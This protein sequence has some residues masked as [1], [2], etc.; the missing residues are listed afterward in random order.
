MSD[1]DDIDALVNES[2]SWAKKRQPFTSIKNIFPAKKQKFTQGTNISFNR[3]HPVIKEIVELSNAGDSAGAMAKAENKF[4][5]AVALHLQ[6]YASDDTDNFFI[7]AIVGG[8]RGAKSPVQILVGFDNAGNEIIETVSKDEIYAIEGRK[9]R[10]RIEG[11]LPSPSTPMEV[12]SQQPAS[13]ES[14]QEVI[15]EEEQVDDDSLAPEDD[16]DNKVEENPYSPVDDLDSDSGKNHD[17]EPVATGVDGGNPVG[18]GQEPSSPISDMLRRLLGN[19]IV[20]DFEKLGLRNKITIE[21]GVDADGIAVFNGRNG[22]PIRAE[23]T[24]GGN[25]IDTVQFKGLIQDTAFAGVNAPEDAKPY[26]ADDMG[27]K[28]RAIF[29]PKILF[30]ESMKGRSN[31]LERLRIVRKHMRSLSKV[32]GFDDP[33]QLEAFFASWLMKDATTRL[34]GIPGTGKTTVISSAATLMCN[35]YGFNTLKRYM[36]KGKVGMGDEHEPY[37]YPN[38]QEYNVNYGSKEYEDVRREWESWRFND[39][40]ADSHHSGAYVYDFR[41]L[42]KGESKLPMKPEAFRQLLFGCKVTE[43]LST[44]DNLLRA[45]FVQSTP[46]TKAE[47]SGIFGGSIPTTVS[48][49]TNG[50]ATWDGHKLYNDS[51][52]NQGYGLREFMLEHFY[53]SRLDDGS[54]G[55]DLI[56]NEMLMEIGIAKVDYDKRAEEILYGIEIRQV[57]TTDSVTGNTVASYEFEPTPRPIVTQPIKFFN[58]ANRSGS[59]VEDAILGLIAEKT[60]EY[61]G[62]TFTS[63]SFISFMDTNPHQKGNDL[64]FVDRIDMEL[65]LGSLSLG[66]RFAALSERYGSKA[67]GSVPQIQ[68]IKRMENAS[69]SSDYLL[70]MRFKDLTSLWTTV[71]KVPFNPSGISDEKGGALLDISMLSVL[72]TQRFMVKEKGEKVFGMEHIYS[73]DDEVYASPLVDI[74]TTTNLSYESQHKDEIAK[75]GT[76]DDG[77]KSQAPVLIKRMLGFRFTNSLIKMT[78]ALAFLRGKEYVTRQE[79]IDSLPYC[80]GHRLGPAREGEDPK[81]RDSGIVSDGMKFTNEQEFIRQLIVHGYLL[82]DTQ[83]LLG[84]VDANTPSMFDIWDGFL[85]TCIREIESGRPYWSYE[86]NILLNLKTRVRQGGQITPVH[87]HIGTMVVENVKRSAKT[88]RDG[89]SYKER[90]NRYQEAISSP[91]LLKAKSRFSTKQQIEDMNADHSAN[92]FY[93]IRGLIARDELL[94]SDDKEKLL[95]LCESKISSITGKKMLLASDDI[96]SSSIAVIA[97]DK[98]TPEERSGPVATQFKW[99]TYGDALGVWGRLISNGSNANLGIANL[100]DG[101]LL[102]VDGV[103][104]EANQN[105]SIMEVFDVGSEQH[106]SPFFSKLKA[107][108]DF[109]APMVIGNGNILGNTNSTKVG[110]GIVDSVTMPEYVLAVKNNIHKWLKNET[111]DFSMND[112]YMACFK[113]KHYKQGAVNGFEGITGDDDLR[114]WLRLR[115]VQGEQT[116]EKATI[117]LF[118]GVT[119]SAMKP[120]SVDKDGHPVAWQVLDFDDNET[121]NAERYFTSA[122]WA[123]EK[124]EDCG[125]LTIQD[126]RF[127]SKNINDRIV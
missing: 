20:G 101:D 93:R 3:K 90:L 17:A 24:K 104:L 77:T 44:E 2:T 21:K 105:F 38:G 91:M 115:V 80:V 35:S 5:Q 48:F 120:T 96:V 30:D 86:D 4:Q 41:F 60:V 22:S 34:T 67:E 52:G 6:K 71:G 59:G 111:L 62:R 89:M 8:R 54:R 102:D 69:D 66:S 81:G 31:T 36:A 58:E 92:E 51:G 87:W 108:S 85:N 121:Y 19:K 39:W 16:T 49:D 127:Y 70:P 55:R 65:Y 98:Y 57:T 99:R 47:L 14:V 18:G 46:I 88:Q 33:A 64:A 32:F 13:Q 23:L 42:Q 110:F 25:I 68:L 73:Y 9:W 107:V 26:R 1:F 83:S 53:D 106:E 103:G 82:R 43:D 37:I 76:G 75:F 112:G 119:S 63:P 74:S 45:T 27:G 56:A 84:P 10:G 72:F 79:V 61:R 40:V 117:G 109:L 118:I 78:R 126:M 125:N 95:G 11:L 50:I 114:L 122:I 28:L 124:F 97:S 7:R 113:L 123:D 94:F 116:G 29:L 12:V 100:G 15:E